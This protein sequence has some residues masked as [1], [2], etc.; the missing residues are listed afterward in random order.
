[1]LLTNSILTAKFSVLQLCY[2]KFYFAVM[3]FV[4]LFYHFH[5]KSFCYL[6]LWT[7]YKWNENDED[8]IN[9]HL[10]YSH[11]TWN[12]NEW[13]KPV[14]RMKI[15]VRNICVNFCVCYKRHWEIKRR[16]EAEREKEFI[17]SQKKEILGAKHI[18]CIFD[19]IYE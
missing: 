5:L 16:R 1:M 6:R 18:E 9:F 15:V 7:C 2:R 4:S 19:I 14:N 10:T 17:K 3:S 13:Q 11:F 8:E 12:M